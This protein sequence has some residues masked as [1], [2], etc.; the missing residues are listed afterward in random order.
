MHILIVTDQHAESLGGVQVS[1]R[2]QRRYLEKAGH[3]V[4]VAASRLHRRGYVSQDPGYVDLPSFP[5]TRD[6]EYSISW[7]GRRTDRALAAALRGRPPV[8]LVHVQG[9]FWGAMIGYRAARGLGVPVVHTLHNHVDA[10][11]RAVAPLAALTAPIAFQGLRLWRWV[12]LGK[13][14]VARGRS[15]P[16]RSARPIGAWKYLAELVAEAT[17]VTAPSH[18]FAQLLRE[19]GVAG[20][21]EVTPTG[22][23]DEV[24]AEVLA[25]GP[26]ST[27]TRPQLIWLGRMSPEKRVLEFIDAI[28]V[29]GIDTDVEL[30][31]AG[32]LLPQVQRRIAQHGL[33]DRVTIPGP[34]PYAAALAVIRDADLLV[35]T[36]RGFETQGM[37]P[38]E[39][40]ALGTPTLFADGDIADDVGVEPAWRVGPSLPGDDEVAPLARALARAVTEL[41]LELELDLDVAK[42]VRV[43]PYLSESFAQSARTAQMLTI[44]A[45][46]ATK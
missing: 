36:S 37:T 35:Q 42:A 22:V 44:Y 19:H 26:R 15:S 14:R 10:G 16:L 34:V 8:D 9:D 11:T 45:L 40:A 38:F 41:E 4:S 43:S 6:R 18:H 27:R 2:L 1:I 46:S 12:V 5:I 17:V 39:A 20:H 25:A 21:I 32:L 23:D 30:Y 24:I 31:G 29:S 3:T 28:A 7:P 33:G 13:P